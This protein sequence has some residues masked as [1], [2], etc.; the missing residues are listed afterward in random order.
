MSKPF[1]QYRQIFEV[2]SRRG[3]R[4]PPGKQKQTN[5]KREKKKCQ[6]SCFL[7]QVQN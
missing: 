3:R 7:N 6:K 1:Y 2:A 5:H 4:S